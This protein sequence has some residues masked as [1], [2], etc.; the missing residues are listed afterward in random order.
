MFLLIANIVYH[1]RQILGAET[2]DTVASLPVQEFA[3]DRFVIDGWEL[4]PLSFPIH[5]AIGKS[6]RDGYGDMNMSFRAAHLMKDESVGL[7]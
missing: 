1:P 3:V 4:A 7:Q 5:S 2:H 6:R